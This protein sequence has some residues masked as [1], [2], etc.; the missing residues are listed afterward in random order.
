MCKSVVI[1]EDSN[2][3]LEEKDVEV[4][5]YEDRMIA[6]AHSTKGFVISRPNT[7]KR[8]EIPSGDIIFREQQ[9]E[10]KNG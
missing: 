1:D 9:K 3:E 2:I 4:G 8:I 5:E 6:H 10:I 7:G